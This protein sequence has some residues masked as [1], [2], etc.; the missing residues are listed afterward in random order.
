ME[1]IL[2]FFVE[3]I[4][5]GCLSSMKNKAFVLLTVKY[6]MRFEAYIV[7]IL[8][9]EWYNC[10]MIVQHWLMGVGVYD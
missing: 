7:I 10:D 8:W 5:Y 6:N 4:C 9:W 2:V 1:N 3:N